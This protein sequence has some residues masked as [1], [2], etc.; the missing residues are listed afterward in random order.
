MLYH[1]FE[2]VCDADYTT[3]DVVIFLNDEEIFSGEYDSLD[4]LI[5]PKLI[6][7]TINN[8]LVTQLYFHDSGGGP[9]VP[10]N[11]FF[12]IMDNKV[13]VKREVSDY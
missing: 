3:N 1:N 8:K 11:Y 4:A 6:K 5:N 13:E 9:S 2:N 7:S 10:M 12:N